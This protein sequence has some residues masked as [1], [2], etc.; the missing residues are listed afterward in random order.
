MENDG[1]AKLINENEALQVKEKNIQY[2]ILNEKLLFDYFL[3]ALAGMEKQT[4]VEKKQVL[5]VE[6]QENKEIVI[7]DKNKAIMN[8]AGAIFVFNSILPLI[9]KLASTS[10]INENEAYKLWFWQIFHISNA[11][12]LDAYTQNKYEFKVEYIDYLTAFLCSF[13]VIG[14]KARQGFTLSK[15]A[16]TFINIFKQEQAVKEQNAEKEKGLLASFF[17]R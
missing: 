12:L 7:F 14:L 6:L 13:Y 11:V 16:D 15:I 4:I 3:T 1:N 17:K 8:E 2:D 10:N 5:G 9:N